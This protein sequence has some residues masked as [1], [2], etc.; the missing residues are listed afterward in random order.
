MLIRP[1]YWLQKAVPLS[2]GY[3][4]WIIMSFCFE[5]ASSSQLTNPLILSWFS[6]KKRCQFSSLYNCLSFINARLYTQNSWSPINEH[7]SCNCRWCNNRKY[8]LF[9][10]YRQVSSGLEWGFWSDIISRKVE[11]WLRVVVEWFCSK[12]WSLNYAVAGF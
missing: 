12:F 1:W 3:L 10:H 4:E 7:F 6:D 8:W 11:K 5:F 9:F 2:Q